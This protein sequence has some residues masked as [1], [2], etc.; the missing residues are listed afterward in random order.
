M[1]SKGATFFLQVC[2][3]CPPLALNPLLPARGGGGGASPCTRC[4][5]RHGRQQLPALPC[6]P[7]FFLVAL[8]YSCGTLAAPPT[9]VMG[10]ALQI[11]LQ[12]LQGA[13]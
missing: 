12:R 8:A 9:Q 2:S 6:P 4:P 7:P 1:H 13:V 3:G 10:G 11:L 5:C